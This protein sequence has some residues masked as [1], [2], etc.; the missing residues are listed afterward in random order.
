MAAT[1]EMTA[2]LQAMGKAMAEMDG[3]RKNAQNQ[4]FHNNYADL[5]AVM[6]SIKGPLERNGLV[7]TQTIETDGG[8]TCT[9]VTTVWHSASGESMSS[10]A[11][12]SPEKAGPQALGSCISYMRRYT[13]KGLFCLSDVDDDGEAAVSHD[14]VNSLELAADMKEA[15]S[16]ADLDRIARKGQTL[17][18]SDKDE[19]RR[20]YSERRRA[21]EGQ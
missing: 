9:L 14:E 19:L 10:R 12:L 18:A 6:E 2:L 4:H 17:R 7:L 8:G 21:L 3:P 15:K 16:L 20:I 1:N 5:S 13:I 11:P